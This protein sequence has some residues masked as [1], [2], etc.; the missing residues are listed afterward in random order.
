M[1][2]KLLI[3]V[4][5]DVGKHPVILRCEQKRWVKKE[6]SYNRSQLLKFSQKRKK[7]RSNFTK[8]PMDGWIDWCMYIL[9]GFDVDIQT[10]QRYERREYIT[11]HNTL[12]LLF[13]KDRRSMYR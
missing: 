5:H 2:P 13:N 11:V 6:Q 8:I 10:N 1:H 12:A 4:D 3:R 7:K 9:Q